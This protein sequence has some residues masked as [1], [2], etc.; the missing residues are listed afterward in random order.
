MRPHPR[1]LGRDRFHKRAQL[2]ALFDRE[3]LHKFRRRFHTHYYTAEFMPTCLIARGHAK[4]PLFS[5]YYFLAIFREDT[6][7]QRLWSVLWIEVLNTQDRVF[8]RLMRIISNEV[9]P[10]GSGRL[11]QLTE[12]KR[13]EPKSPQV[14]KREFDERIKE[15]DQKLNHE[16]ETRIANIPRS[17]VRILLKNDAY[18]QERDRITEAVLIEARDSIESTTAR[19][20]AAT[21][22]LAALERE[23]NQQLGRSKK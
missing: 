18:R 5:G 6:D 2:L 9:L 21:R 3:G 10:L 19:K 1:A 8:K 4:L 22:R 7:L 12:E 16:I 11:Q 14:R 20:N 13:E 23:Q 17:Q 15:E